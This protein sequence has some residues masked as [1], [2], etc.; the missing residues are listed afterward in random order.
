[1]IDKDILAEMFRMSTK[2]HFEKSPLTSHLA[3]ATA[4]DDEVLEVVRCA[5]TSAFAPHMLMA[6]VHSLVMGDPGCDLARHFPSVSGRERPNEDPF[7]A[8]K[9]FVLEHKDRIMDIISKGR[10]NKTIFRRSACFRAA[11]V[12][13]ARLNGWD[14]VHLVD[15]GCSAGLNLLNDQWRIRYGDLGEVGP[16]DSPVKF[17]IEVREGIPPMGDVPE[18]LSRTGIDFDLF[19][20]NDPAQENWLLGFLFPDDIGMVES[21]RGALRHL[22]MVPPNFV[23]GSVSEKLPGV[24]AGLPGDDP[25]VVIHSMLFY[26]LDPREKV[27]INRAIVE[28][29]KNRPTVRIGVEIIGREA[30]II[31]ADPM[32]EDQLYLGSAEHNAEWMSWSGSSEGTD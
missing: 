5:N 15:I 21:T 17:N 30:N 29:A 28:C 11:L 32:A 4:D 3:N 23:Q 18:I 10:V 22:R 24:L 25:V 9:A 13:A 7:P 6:T 26:R 27:V 16:E 8:F 2:Q 31:L 14:K 20:L 12:E 1:M 19:D